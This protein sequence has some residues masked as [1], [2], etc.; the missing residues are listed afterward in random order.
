[1][2][3]KLFN[4]NSISVNLKP[5]FVISYRLNLSLLNVKKSRI[6]LLKLTSKSTLC[7]KLISSRFSQTVE[8]LNETS[9]HSKVYV[10]DRVPTRYKSLYRYQ[11]SSIAYGVSQKTAFRCPPPARLP[12]ATCYYK[13]HHTR[14]LH[15]HFGYPYHL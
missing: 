10:A 12:P 7:T 4:S 8:H 13:H 3:T 2:K 9:L 14:S 6:R 1:M 15:H 5:R 11:Y